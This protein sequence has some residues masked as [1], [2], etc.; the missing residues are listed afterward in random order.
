MKTYLI[1]DI[2]DDDYRQVAEI[3]NSNRQF[4]RNHLGVECVN[5]GF[6]AEEARTM[7]EAGFRPCVIVNREN[8]AVQ[9]VLD[10]K[11]GSEVYL[12]LLMLAADLQGKGM[13]RAIYAWFESEMRRLGSASVRLD[14]VNDHPDHIVPFWAGLGFLEGERVTLDWGKKR[15]KAVVMRK[16]I[17]R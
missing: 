14:V 12:S 11:S 7:R 1:R 8:Q 13:G 6:V 4:L 17:P 9:G 3:Y 2:C 15:S 16:N 5:E 10:Y